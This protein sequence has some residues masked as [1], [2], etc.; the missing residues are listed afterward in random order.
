MT[1]PRV[2]NQSVLQT[3][4]GIAGR[5]GSTVQDSQLGREQNVSAIGTGVRAILPRMV[6]GIL[7]LEIH[8]RGAGGDAIEVVR[9][10]LRLY[11]RFTSA[12][13]APRKV[14]ITR[15]LTVVGGNDCLGD[16]RGDMVSAVGKINPLLGVY[17][18]GAVTHH[19]LMTHIIGRNRQPALQSGCTGARV[20]QLDIQYAA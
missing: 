6:E 16:K 10:P 17:A 19:S 1:G 11:E 13:G 15:C 3:I 4:Q 20:P 7:D 14:S 8:G 18:K 5:Q 2:G 9:I 12:I